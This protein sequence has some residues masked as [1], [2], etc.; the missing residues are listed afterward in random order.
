[1]KEY[2]HVSC[3]N[4]S[5]QSITA[6]LLVSSQLIWFETVRTW[7]LRDCGFQNQCSL[8]LKEITPVSDLY[9][10][11]FEWHGLQNLLF[12]SFHPI[13]RHL[14]LS[15]VQTSPPVP[16]YMRRS[17]WWL[18]KVKGGRNRSFPNAFSFFQL[19]L[20]VCVHVCNVIGVQHI[21]ITGDETKVKHS[22][23]AA[24]RTALASPCRGGQLPHCAGPLLPLVF[25][26]AFGLK[27][28]HRHFLSQG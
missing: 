10:M 12:T 2:I 21:L 3:T 22:S 16:D 27:S 8:V 24:T 19:R 14:Q 28:S 15:C 20:R 4:I 18:C 25:R 6:A 1:M 17:L 26:I 7:P 11:L 9:F 23:T 5:Q 13:S